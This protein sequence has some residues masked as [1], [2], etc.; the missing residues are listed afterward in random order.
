[1]KCNVINQRESS[2]MKEVKDLLKEMNDRIKVLEQAEQQKEQ[3]QFA[4]PGR[5]SYRGP[6]H[7]RGVYNR[8]PY[9]RGRG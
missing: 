4:H 1:M 7:Y 2:D 9:T 3:N 5:G 6:R 8:G